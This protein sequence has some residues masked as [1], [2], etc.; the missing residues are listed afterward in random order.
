MFF[1][2]LAFPQFAN[3]PS[4][5]FSPTVSSRGTMS[6]LSPLL[7][8]RTLFLFLFFLATVSAVKPKS[9][10]IIFLLVDDLGYHNTALTN[11]TVNSPNIV[12]LLAT[13]ARQLLRH[14]S[15]KVC[16]PSRSSLLSGRMPI[17]V[18][19]LNAPFVNSSLGGVDTRMTLLPEKLK[20]AGYQTA[21]FGKWHLGAHQVANLPSQRGFDYHFGFLGGGEDH[22]TQHSYEAFDSIDLWGGSNDSP[23]KERNGTNSCLLYG[24][25]AVDHINNRVDP[26]QPQFM[27]LAL[28]NCHAAYVAPEI[29]KDK[30]IQITPRTTTISIVRQWKL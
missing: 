6:V 2:F 5:R 26:S 23:N 21:A 30:N 12:E 27:Y 18:N 3:P 9:P 4:Q 13:S 1:L 19:E 10:H 22:N 24:G 11:P 28:Q 17:H 8:P 7:G 20:D 15:Y 25:D 16:S 29:Y 14:Y